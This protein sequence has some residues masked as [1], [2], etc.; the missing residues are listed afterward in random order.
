M[1]RLIFHVDVNSAYLS[2]EAVRH[3]E[4]TG[5]DIRT[6]P[7]AV[8]GNP[9]KRTGII[10]AKS[11]P[12]KKLGIKTGEPVSMALRKCPDLFLAPPDFALYEKNSRAFMDICRKYAPVVEKFSIDECFLDM[13][14]TSLL[15]PDPIEIAHRI[16]DEIR[17][18]L[19]F[20]VNIGIGENKLLA[21]MA[22]DFEK[23]DRVHT[24]FR[25][26][27][28]EKFLPLPIEDL[29]MTG[30]ATA[31][32]LK[33]HSV[34]TIG[35]AAKM[36][37]PALSSILGPKHGAQLY[38]R[39]RGEDDSPVLAEPEE[40]KGYSISTTLEEDITAAEDAKSVLLALSDSVSAR[41]RADGKKSATVTVTIRSRDFKNHSH[42][43]TLS[44]P[45]DLTMEIYERACRLFDALWDKET[46]LRLL[47]ISL[48]HLENEKDAQLT[49]FTDEKR[50]KE[51]KMDK[52]VD[53]IRKK[54]GAG[55][56]IRGGVYKSDLS[57]G[58]K[59][60]AQLESKKDSK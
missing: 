36:G 32:T 4:K 60:K 43:E 21:K 39:A 50:E 45:T 58:R 57:V 3:L 18:T 53:S 35:D 10:L 37:A 26:E 33:K 29:F 19:G 24:L 40:A 54:F 6:I 17:N 16:K 59:Y 55:K 25:H 9:E 23:P 13:T 56:V 31:E 34:Y 12:A 51:E 44:S 38:A 7:A 8:G 22:S 28:S 15:Y 48:T 49:F 5:E 20:T 47:G 2:W 30:H 27:L 46:P 52:T 11:I 14:G 42:G 41:M 1:T